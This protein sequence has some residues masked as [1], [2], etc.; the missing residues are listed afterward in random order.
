MKTEPRHQCMIYEGAPSQKLPMLAAIIQ[1][2]LNEGFRCLYLNSP[3]MVAGMRSTLAALGTDVESEIAKTRLILSGEPVSP[4]G[5]FNSTEMLSQLES[6]LDDAIKDGFKGLWASGDMTWE[7][8]PKQD[9]SKLVDYEL[10]LEE[11]FNKRKELQ[12][13]CQYHKDTLP[14]NV[15]RQSLLVHRSVI[16]SDTISRMNMHFKK[17]LWPADLNTIRQLDASILTILGL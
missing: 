12:G 9:F 1:R 17:S 15:M 5:E 16:I 11:L 10:Q 2:K 8:G 3:P 13:V 7:F 4:D 6:A 14:L